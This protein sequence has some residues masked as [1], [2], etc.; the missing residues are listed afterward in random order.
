[1]RCGAVVAFLAAF[2]ASWATP[3][4]GLELIDYLSS[5]PLTSA[6]IYPSQYPLIESEGAPSVAWQR[7]LS[8]RQVQ[9]CLKN[10][11]EIEHDASLVLQNGSYTTPSGT[12]SISASPALQIVHFTSGGTAT[13]TLTLT[14]FPN[15][16]TLGELTLPF[17]CSSSYTSLGGDLGLRIYQLNA[18]PLGAGY[19]LQVPVWTN[20]L[21]DACLW[22]T[23]K[24]TDADC[25]WWC[26]FKL[27][28]SM[29]FV[30][31]PDNNPVYVK[32]DTDQHG[33][34]IRFFDL[35]EFFSDRL[36]PPYSWVN[37]D[38]RDVSNYS[39][40]CLSA[41]GVS[42]NTFL[43][44]ATPA[45]SEPQPFITNR[46]CGIGNDATI[47]SNYSFYDFNFHSIAVT[48]SPQIVYDATCA[49]WMDFAGA[50]YQNPPMGWGKPQYWQVDHRPTIIFDSGFY[51]FVKQ[52]LG[53]P[54]TPEGEPV[55][56]SELIPTPLDQ[57]R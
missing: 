2:A 5:E 18:E 31:D 16:V 46:L 51:G 57:L 48:S 1:M 27:F 26:T 55:G 29:V 4:Y 7:A 36:S 37:G 23:E 22:A 53:N 6:A 19:G 33:P 45:Y 41:I 24:S 32:F 12:F 38:C 10:P 3:P 50:S 52:Y 14:G 17:T 34:A 13:V 35:K 20:V 8:P 44:Y 15:F 43:A 42:L 49:Q 54:P 25:R 28:H 39:M 21:E 56:L 11:L 9:I 47:S 40:I 30:Y